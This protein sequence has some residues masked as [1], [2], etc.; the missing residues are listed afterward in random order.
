M[1]YLFA[2]VKPRIDR[3][4]EAARKADIEAAEMQQ[5]P[6]P[7]AARP[8][9]DELAPRALAEFVGGR[10]VLAAEEERRQRRNG[11]TKAS[12]PTSS[13]DQKEQQRIELQ[14]SRQ[15]KPKTGKQIVRSMGRS[16]REHDDAID[17][18]DE[19]ST[20]SLSEAIDEVRTELDAVSKHGRFVEGKSAGVAE[21]VYDQFPELA[22]MSAAETRKRHKDLKRELDDLR[23]ERDGDGR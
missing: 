18:V 15:H 17:V 13:R 1:L 23:A 5:P 16:A 8:G 14:L 19:V 3:R 11:A 7:Q 9:G 2:V 10:D 22:S 21:W 12:V 6:P 4:R 20:H